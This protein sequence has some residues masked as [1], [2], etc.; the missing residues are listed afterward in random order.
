MRVVRPGGYLLAFGGTRTYH[1]L[2]CAIEDAGWELDDCLCWLYGSGFPKH[3]SKLKPAWEPIIM[4]RR[5]MDGAT[6]LRIDDCRL[7]SPDPLRGGGSPPYRYY[8]DN[9]RPFHADHERTATPSHDK[10]RW[11]ANV[12]IDEAAAAAIDEQTGSLRSGANPTR[13]ASAKTKNA[14]GAF[15]GQAENPARG[16]DSGG[17]SRF[18]YCAKASR[19]E[20]DAGL[21][22][23]EEAPLHWSSG[24][25]NPGAFQSE[26]TKKSAKNNHPTVKPIALMRW[27]CRLV[28]P[29]GGRVLDMFAGSFS[30]GCAC[31]LEG[32]AFTGIELDER[33]VRIGDARMTH[34]RGV[35][36]ADASVT[37][38]EAAD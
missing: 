18:Y 38:A 30:T 24:D 20:R 9:P 16:A 11:P 22:A 10:G 31:E 29:P 25:A 1:R 14:Y 26:G 3:E 5:P 27:L 7:A 28:T 35:A 34:W 19:H 17:A 37:K 8:G 12:V 13:R 2:A 4:A 15:Q 23:F 36:R 32:F 6:A 33:F 21:E